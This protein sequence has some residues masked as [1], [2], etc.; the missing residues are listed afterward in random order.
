MQLTNKII[1]FNILVMIMALIDRNMYRSDCI[2]DKLFILLHHYM[3]LFM[4]LSGILFGL[5]S[6]NALIIIVVIIL[7]KTMG[8]CILTEWNNSLCKSKGNVKGTGFEPLTHHLREIIFKITKVSFD[9]WEF[10]TFLLLF[11][12]AY[13]L[14][15]M[16]KTLRQEKGYT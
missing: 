8:G 15:M 5:Y 13:N 1:I 14:Y 4:A 12:L 7:W 2:P 16:Y 3:S 11:V 9:E 6:L 10:D